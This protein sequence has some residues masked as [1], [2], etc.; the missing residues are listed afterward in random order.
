MALAGFAP[1]EER[2]PEVDVSDFDLLEMELSQL[3][4]SRDALK[5]GKLSEAEKGRLRDL[6]AQIAEVVGL[7]KNSK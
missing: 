7:L 5:S 6:E 2:L 4:R 3:E 1:T